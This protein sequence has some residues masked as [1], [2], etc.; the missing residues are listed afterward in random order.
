MVSHDAETRANTNWTVAF[1]E[2]SYGSGRESPGFPPSAEAN[3]H[4]QGRPVLR[5][6]F[7]RVSLCRSVPAP[8]CN[9]QEASRTTRR[10]SLMRAPVCG[11]PESPKASA[12]RRAPMRT[13]PSNKRRVSPQSRSDSAALAVALGA[14]LA[15][16]AYLRINLTDSLPHGLCLVAP[17][18]RAGVGRGELVVACPPRLYAKVGAQARIFAFRWMSGR[19]VAPAEVRGRRRRGHRSPFARGSLSAISC[20]PTRRC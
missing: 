4:G 14:I 20:C 7:S 15:A 3:W 18:P 2:S 8:L 9:V 1:K 6:S 10:S 12:H 13:T 17:V 5:T 19:R 11:R 16:R